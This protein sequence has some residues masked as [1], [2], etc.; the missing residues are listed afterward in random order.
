MNYINRFAQKIGQV[1]VLVDPDKFDL[2][3]IASFSKAI[4]QAHVDYLFIGGSTVDTATFRSVV[5]ALKQ[6]VD[7]PLIGFP[8][9]VYQYDDKLDALLYLSLLSGRNPEYLIGQH[10][11]TAKEIAQ[12]KFE[13]LPTAY[14]LIDGESKSAVSYV[15]Q[16]SPIPQDQFNIIERTA[17]AGKLQGKQLLYLDA[18]S[19]ANKSVDP[20]IIAKLN[21]INLPLIVGG[22]IRSIEQIE[23]YQEAGANVIVIGNEIERN[24]DFLLDI[25]F[26]IKERSQSLKTGS[27]PR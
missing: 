21:S 27:N 5:H 19:G 6:Q 24:I 17:L 20:S 13:T 16:T 7:I 11:H 15:S 14:L 18:G 22:G 2:N 12:A 23:A 3:S 26:Y 1:A 9:D 10:I 25:Q 8:G 4:Q